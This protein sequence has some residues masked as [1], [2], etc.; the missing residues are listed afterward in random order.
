M[1]LATPANWFDLDLNPSTSA[2]SIARLVE[3][4]VGGGAEQAE[5]VLAASERSKVINTSFVER[6][7]GTQ[8]QLGGRKK[9]KAYTFSKELSFH[10][11]STWL[12]VVPTAS[13]SSACSRVTA[14]L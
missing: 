12:V 14:R 2:E 13:A 3:D 11:A 10:A 4:R 6:Y 1:R 8:R 9:R 5:Q 7:H